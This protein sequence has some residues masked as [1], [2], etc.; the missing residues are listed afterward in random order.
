M[1]VETAQSS[2]NKN[3]RDWSATFTGTVFDHT[4]IGFYL[5]IDDAYDLPIYEVS[6]DIKEIDFLTGVM[7]RDCFTTPK[8]S[9]RT[10]YPWPSR[11][12]LFLAVDWFKQINDKLGHI[13]GDETLKEICDVFT[14]TIWAIWSSRKSWWR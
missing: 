5:N 10:E 4:C 3:N 2:C 12:V 6:R 8:Y 13:A 7:G 14:R 1:Y 9:K 11:M